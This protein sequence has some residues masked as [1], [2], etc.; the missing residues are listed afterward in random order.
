MLFVP[1]VMSTTPATPAANGLPVSRSVVTVTEIV[2]QGHCDVD[3]TLSLGTL[4][5]WVR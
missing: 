3:G 1:P 4:L 5:K 2:T